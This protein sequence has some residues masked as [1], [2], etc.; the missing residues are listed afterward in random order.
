MIRS[1]RCGVRHLRILW[2]RDDDHN[3]NFFH[4]KASQRCR[5]NYITKL[6][7]AVGNWCVGQEHVNDTI[8][9]F[10]QTLF[11]SGDLSG[12]TEV[13]KVIPH[14][15]TPDMNEKL[16]MEFTIEKV[17]VVLKKMAPLKSP[18]L[19]GMPLLFYQNYWSLIGSDVTLSILH[20]LISGM[21]PQSLCHSFITQIPKVKNPEY[22]TKLSQ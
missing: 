2:L 22:V 19:D 21:L 12:L 18:G 6:H 11:T 10:Y 4:S 9:N 16:D 20:Y 1:P 15:I 14:V 8:I 17:E 5:R 7:D 13:I 3:T